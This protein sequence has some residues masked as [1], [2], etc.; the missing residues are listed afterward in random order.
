NVVEYYLK[1]ASA[2]QAAVQGTL[3]VLPGVLSS[4]LTTIAVFAPLSFLVG[5]L[6]NVL[7][8]LRVVLIAALTASLIQAL[9]V[10]SRHLSGSLHC[11]EADPSRLR[12]RFDAGFARFRE[13]VGRSA[14][15]AIRWRYAVLA[16]VLV[17]ILGSFGYLAG[18][19]IGSEAMPAIDGDVLEARI[20]MPQ[21]T[22]LARTQTVAFHVESA[23]RTLDKRLTPEQPKGQPLVRSTQ[24]RFNHNPRAGEAG[25]HVATVMVDLLTAERRN[26]NLDELTSAWLAEIGDIPG[27]QNL[28]IQ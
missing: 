6:G 25:T 28:I 17:L 14:D 2:T 12:V 11:L 5:E 8:V 4:F 20:L 24:V 22:P 19:H 21:G 16:S 10:L 23:M 18:G 1:G 3:G 26:I 7:K 15:A 27:L 9:L 13:A